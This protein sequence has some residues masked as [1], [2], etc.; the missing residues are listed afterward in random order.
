MRS[1]PGS[2]SPGNLEDNGQSYLGS[3]PDRNPRTYSG[4]NAP[5]N[6]ERNR[7]SNP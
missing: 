1:N 2:N 3:N 7:W 4:R 6:P 5:T